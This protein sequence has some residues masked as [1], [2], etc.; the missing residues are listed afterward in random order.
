MT[1]T[2]DPARLSPA[3]APDLRRRLDI[4]GLRAI[5]VLLVVAY[6]ARLP[7]PGGFVGVDVFFVVSGFV[8]TA[9][10]LREQSERGRIR[11]GH[12]YLR[13]FMRLAPALALMVG[14]V[15]LVS[16]VVE[17]PFGA[18]QATARTGLGALLLS[19]NGVIGLASGDYFAADAT[20]NPLLN[21]WSLSVEEQFYLVFPALIG[22]GWTLARRRHRAAP[23]LLVTA[24]AL[25]SLALSIAWSF[26]SPIVETLTGFFGGA[27][28]FAFYSSLARA[29]EFAAGALLALAM[30]RLEAPSAATARTIGVAGAGA[31]VLAAFVIHEDR[32][33]PGYD[34]LLPVAGTLLLLFAGAGAGA[35]T[36]A[37]AGKGAGAGAHGTDEPGVHGVSRMLSS[38]G[39]VFLG[40]VSYAWYLWHWPAIVFAGLVFPNRPL[41]LVAA[42][43][44][45]LAPS[46]ASWRFVEQPLRVHRP[47]SRVHAAA[48]VAFTVALPIALCAGLFAGAEAGWGLVPSDEN[49]VASD[50]HGRRR[51]TR[52]ASLRSQH[53]V[54]KAGCVNIDLDP[55]RCRFGPA[56]SRGTILL[57][58]DSQAYAFADGV[59]A[60]GERL[61]L[62]TVATSHTGC[63]FLG[64]ESSGKH[65][66][67][68]AAWQ[69]SIVE[70]AH[71][72]RPA[73]VVIANRSSGY[74][75]PGKRW[76]T[77][78]GEDGKR[79]RSVEVAVARYRDG[80]ERVVRELTSAGLPVV[81]I[82]SIPHMDGFVERTSL[83][84]AAVGA[85][86]FEVARADAEEDRRPAIEVERRLAE[87]IQGVALFDPIPTLCSAVVCAA[88]RDGRTMYR[89]ETH[90]SIAGSL[91]L[92]DELTRILG[93]ATGHPIAPTTL[94]LDRR[95]S[96]H[97]R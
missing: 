85:Q 80:L 93:R 13:R 22:I 8:I 84:T 63:P 86:P 25:P 83:L 89:D 79:A 58:G 17:N 43:A 45:S 38:R 7:I 55:E 27:E 57:A 62:D 4:Q 34:A 74:V 32:P 69:R 12:S 47:R 29:W 94:A 61:G 42:A 54:V 52:H 97:A 39:L 18:Q 9:M 67:P 26:G 87:A 16:A 24:I 50:E 65:G 37:G 92:T 36:G 64:L 59:I 3:S 96:G 11:F 20:T 46:I 30:P 40:D 53:A 21:T 6:H 10:L 41:V 78:A 90:L 48:I 31:L 95:P 5:A 88:D 35:G 68:C 72:N 15:A 1:T 91:L 70:W 81:L 73:V 44:A 49:G 75:R 60:A 56:E 28:S 71:A 2:P 82:A 33:F 77:I 66:F 14:A 76:R 51:S 19:A 23:L